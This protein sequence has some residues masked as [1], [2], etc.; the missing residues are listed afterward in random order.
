MGGIS[1]S[2]QLAP[3]YICPSLNRN[4]PDRL[5][6]VGPVSGHGGRNHPSLQPGDDQREA[7]R[8]RRR[9]QEAV[10]FKLDVLSLSLS[11]SCSALVT[12]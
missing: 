6:E 10:L 3:S 1:P 8:Q 9:R 5:P 12:V 4:L 2:C 11:L 7:H